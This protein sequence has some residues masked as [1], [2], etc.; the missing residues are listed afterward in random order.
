MSTPW[1]SHAAAYGATAAA[2]NGVSRYLQKIVRKYRLPDK[3]LLVHQFTDQMIANKQ[4]L[5]PLRGVP[6]V[7]NVDGFGGQEVKIAKYNDFTNPRVPHVH[8][9]FKLFYK[10]DTNT[11]APSQVLKLH[12]RPDVVIYE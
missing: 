12:P 11:M 3:M 6:L 7:L 10:E 9:G 4:Q 1:M 2:V 8:A 5:K